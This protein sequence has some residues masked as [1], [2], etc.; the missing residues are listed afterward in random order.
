VL[1]GD[2][3]LGDLTCHAPGGAVRGDQ[4]RVPGLELAE[5]AHEGVVLRIG[6]LGPRLDIVQVVVA[7]DLLAQR[8]DPRG[9][10]GVR[11]HGVTRG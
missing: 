5:L 2:E 8:G 6:D 7:A 10:V 4:L 9:R 11:A 3:R 1:N